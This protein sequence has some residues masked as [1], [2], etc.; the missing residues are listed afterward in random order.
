M[1]QRVGTGRLQD[2]YARVFCIHFQHFRVTKV[3]MYSETRAA[4]NVGLNF[5][6]LTLTISLDPRTTSRIIR[7]WGAMSPELHPSIGKQYC[8]AAR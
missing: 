7:L 4:S 8:R 3:G 5:H 1:C 2:N 6:A